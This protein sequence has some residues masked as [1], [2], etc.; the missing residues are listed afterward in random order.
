MRDSYGITRQR[1]QTLGSS[2]R[3][4]LSQ[5]ARAVDSRAACTAP[6][7]VHTDS[8]AGEAT[9]DSPQPV[10]VSAE[11]PCVRKLNFVR[12][13]MYFPPDVNPADCDWEPLSLPA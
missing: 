12:A 11:Q 8:A 9:Q 1:R 4:A 7:S 10:N 6:P 3:R 5:A 13:T 2:V